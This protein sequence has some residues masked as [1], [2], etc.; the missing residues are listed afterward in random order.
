MQT[1]LNTLYIQTQGTYLNLDHETIKIQLE[2]QT[3]QHV[4]LHHISGVCVFGNVSISPFL[5]HKCA[6][7]GKTIT[8]LTETGR[9]QARTEGPISGNVLLRQAQ[10]LALSNPEQTHRIALQFVLGK[11]Q[12][13]RAVLQRHKRD[14]P[15]SELEAPIQSLQ[16]SIRSLQNC[17]H[18][19]TLRG[20]EGNA[21][22]DYFSVFPV[23]IRNG[24][25]HFT[26]RNKR[27]PRDATNALL[28]FIYALLTSDCSSAIQA[29]GMDPQLG[30][31]HVLRPGRP[32][33]A[34][35]LMEE[36]RS[37]FADRLALS[38]INRQQIQP[39]HFEE[40][41][42]GAVLLND[43]GRKE[44]LMAYQKRK[45][46]SLLHPL[47]KNPIPIGLIFHVQARLL[48]RHLRGDLD[49]YPPYRWK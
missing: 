36:F 28:S 48:A 5:I 34:L 49:L 10:H 12:N 47:F 11:L 30:Y 45:Q 7:E 19:D 43:T 37:W 1:L 27:P 41:P 9:F 44:V 35:D 31:L 15:D 24:Q 20:I 17:S 16:S 42:G 18:L 25:F 3:R 13:S 21:G 6:R 29:V 23:L 32:A 40:R 46:E 33:L 22:A 8:W 39:Q 38:L 4:P 26:D 14:Y 2:G